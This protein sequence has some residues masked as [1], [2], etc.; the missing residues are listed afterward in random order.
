MLVIRMAKIP[1]K[2]HLTCFTNSVLS[3]IKGEQGRKQDKQVAAGCLSFWTFLGGLS[4]R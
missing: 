2:Q 1:K 3:N 4:V